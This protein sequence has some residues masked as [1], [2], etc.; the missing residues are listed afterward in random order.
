MR[1]RKRC[2]AKLFK[3][4][5]N[6]RQAFQE[7]SSHCV[8]SFHAPDLLR[9]TE[10]PSRRRPPTT[11]DASLVLTVMTSCTIVSI[12]LERCR[13]NLVVRY[14]TQT[15]IETRPSTA[16]GVRKIIFP[17]SVIRQRNV[18]NSKNYGLA[19]N[20]SSRPPMKSWSRLILRITATATLK[21]CSSPKF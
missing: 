16:R 21:Y 10:Q 13:Q 5:Q 3:E 7:T 1:C 18:P 12:V 11:S 20:G 4:Y 19:I 2:P 8:V 9:I 17:M 15:C 6:D 14:E